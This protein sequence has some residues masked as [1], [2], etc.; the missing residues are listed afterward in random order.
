MHTFSDDT[1]FDI[2]HGDGLGRLLL[3]A[4]WTRDMQKFI[5]YR[6]L[7]QTIF[8]WSIP[9][10]STRKLRLGRDTVLNYYKESPFRN[11]FLIS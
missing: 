3:F 10:K 11:Y 5:K 4:S 8:G 7:L 2:A 6:F 1:N 9:D